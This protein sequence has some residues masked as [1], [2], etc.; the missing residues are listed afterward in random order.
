M[1]MIRENGSKDMIPKPK[2]EDVINNVVID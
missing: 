1:I 2:V